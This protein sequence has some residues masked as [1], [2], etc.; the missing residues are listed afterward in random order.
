MNCPRSEPQRSQRSAVFKL[1]LAGIWLLSFF[2]I[3]VGTHAGPTDVSAILGASG[4]EWT[5]TDKAGKPGRY[6]VHETNGVS[7]LVSDIPALFLQSTAEMKTGTE[8][9]A[10]VRLRNETSLA[11]AKITGGLGTTTNTTEGFTLSLGAAVGQDGVMATLRRAGQGP[12]EYLVRREYRT[13]WISRRSLGLPEDIRMLVEHEIASLPRL[14]EKWLHVRWQLREDGTRLY[15]EDRLLWDSPTNTVGR[16]RLELPRTTELAALRVEPLTTPRAGFEPIALDG[17]LNAAK[18]DGARLKR[19]QLPAPGALTDVGGVPFALPRPDAHGNDHVDLEPSWFQSGFLGGR[20][21][22][23]DGAFGGRW[24]GAWAV[25]PARIQFAIPAGRYSAIHLLAAADSDPNSIPVVTAQFYIPEAGRP[26][27]VQR[28]DVQRF[29]AP[30]GSA[31]RLPAALDNGKAGSLFLVTIPIEPGMLDGIGDGMELELTKGV[32]LYRAWPDPMYYSFHQAGLPSS[33]HVY[34][35]TLERPPVNVDL[36]ADNSLHV[37]TAPEKP[38]YTA[39]LRAQRPGK[40]TVSV[41]ASTTSFDGKEKTAQKKEVDLVPGQDVKVHFEFALKKHGYHELTLAVRDGAS[42]QTEKRGLAL[43]HRDTRERGNWE[44]DKGPVFGFWN[45]RGAHNTPPEPLPTLIMAL[46]G[47]ESDHGSFDDRTLAEVKEIA[48]K[49][50]SKGYKAFGSG[51]HYVT[52]AFAA[53]LEKLGLEKAKENFLAKL[54]ERY[55]KPD[56]LNRSLFVSFF[57]EPGVGLHTSGVPLSYDGLSETNDYVFTEAEETRFQFFLKGLIEGARIMKQYY[58]DVKCML[59]HGDPGFPVPFLRRSPE[60]RK[61]VDGLSVDIPFFEKLP[62]FQ[63]HQVSLH[64]MYI[65]REEF[66]KAG[67]ERP[68]LPMYEGPCLPT[69]PGSLTSAEHAALSVRNSLLLFVY[70]VD[71]QVG[72]WC[73]FDAGSYW[74]EQH[75]GGGLCD[76]LPLATPKPSYAAFA[77]MTRHLNRRNF[78]KWLPTGSLSTYALQFKHYKEGSRLHVFWT[79]RG[80]RPVTVTVPAGATVAV[81][82]S[83]DNGTDLAVKDGAVTFTVDQ[84]PCYVVGLPDSAKITLG[85]TDH[86]DS[87]PAADSV[88]LSKMGDGRWSVSEERDTAFEDSFK[89]FIRHYPGKMSIRPVD[90]PEGKAGPALAVH[91]ETPARDSKTMPFYTTLVPKK[92]VV[93]PGKASHLGLWVNASAD[94]GRVVYCLR[95]AKGERWISVGTTGSWNCDDI[96]GWSY[97]NFDGWRYL[98]FEL[99]ACSPWDLF[100]EAGSTWWGSYS[101]GDKIPDLPLSIE[102]IIVERRTHAMYVNDPQPASTND[103]LLAG[104]F[105]EYKTAEDKTDRAVQLSQLRMPV[106]AGIAEMDN[107]IRDLA[108]SGVGEPVTIARI[109]VPMQESDG[110]QCHVDFAT[111]PNAVTYE[112]WASPY[113]DGRGAVKLAENLKAPGARVRG[114]RP[115]TDFYLFVAYT[116][117]NKKP[118]KPSQP[119][120]IN[121]KDTFAMK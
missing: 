112:I 77:T 101:K 37:W 44:R 35:M 83:M 7:Y 103:V 39:T 87:V 81:Y 56:D 74:G 118:S 49:Y 43:L 84:A 62:E 27:Q 64:R 13:R 89:A 93:I 24:E 59:P 98:R 68:W 110:T 38:S 114:F 63:L 71:I 85:E 29:A 17:Y 72:G 41:L 102:K 107:P 100:R 23:R 20:D 47:A 22:P 106:P 5:V 10:L 104:L 70:G 60:A 95:D 9:S 1:P 21:S 97:F 33:V 76:P 115:D 48:R 61:L 92:P 34:A 12:R 73:P 67:I 6:T 96:H 46:A 28:A 30:A 109:D 42:V 16:F 54:K 113:P 14:R 15:V 51:D 119:F 120:K 116:D 117:A 121:L 4:G 108:A 26:V 3:P 105:A 82:D 52:A 88:L 94:W 90:A 25:N 66:R 50:G 69:R 45:W 32:R 36:Q 58:P 18:L 19:D 79:I 99:P 78:E 31:S 111:T 80:Q 57:P 2:L 55:V 65:C 86:S 91:L 53:D 75:Y 40:R 8:L 11:S